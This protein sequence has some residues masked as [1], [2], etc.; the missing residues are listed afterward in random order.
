VKAFVA[1]PGEASVEMVLVVGAM[2]SGVS[3]RHHHLAMLTW[4]QI[5]SSVVSL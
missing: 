5:G 4:Q 3:C 1:V 2:A